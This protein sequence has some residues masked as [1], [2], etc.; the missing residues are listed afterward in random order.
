MQ[1]PIECQRI[2]ALRELCEML[3]KERARFKNYLELEEKCGFFDISICK[4][5]IREFNRLE[6][7]INKTF[8]PDLI[9]GECI[10]KKEAVIK[11]GY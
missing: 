3:I 6:E 8:T 7:F 1:T 10:L 9:S 4:R 11:G 2:N 5:S